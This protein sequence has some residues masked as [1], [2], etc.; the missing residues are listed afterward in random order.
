MKLLTIKNLIATLLTSVTLAVLATVLWVISTTDGAR[1][2]LTS[3]LPLSGITFSADTIE[4]SINNHLKLS[5]VR[6]GLG[7]LKIELGT[8]DLRWKPLLLM[9]GTVG[10]QQ[11]TITNLR[12]QDNAPPDNTPLNLAWPKLSGNAQLLDATIARLQISN[13]TYR[14]LQQQ[15]LHVTS[16]AGAV[17]WQDGLLSVSELKLATPDGQASGTIS[18]GF[19]QPS[20]T[21][22]LTVVLK[23]PLAEMDRFSLQIRTAKGPEQFVGKVSV[24]GSSGSRRLLELKGELGMAPNALNLRQLQLNR[25]GRKGALTGA[26]SLAFTTG[27]P[28][29]SLNINVAGLNLGP[30]LNIPTDL[31][32]T[33]TFAGTLDS[34]RGD[35]KLVNRAAGWQAATATAAYS[36]TRAGV[37]LAPFNATLLD[38]SL[39][40]TMD[41][42]WL[43]GGALRAVLNGKNLNPARLDPAWQG[44]ANFTVDGRMTWSETAPL[45]G[46]LRASLLQS[47]LHGQALTGAVQ[48]DFTDSSILLSR[49]A[50]QGKGFDLHASGDLQQRI[51]L[52]AHIT[53]FSRLIPGAA[54]KLQA[55]GWLRWR[56]RQL[57]G[58]LNGSGSRLSYAGTHIAT[59][60]LN[61][62][63][64]Q[65]AGYPLHVSTDLQNVVY[66]IYKLSNVSLE[67]DGTLP[68]HTVKAVLRSGSSAARATLAA[69]YSNGLWKGAITRLA[70]NDRSGA[71]N[72]TAPTAFSASSTHINLAP[73]ALAA[74]KTERLTAAVNLSLNPLLGKVT[75]EWSALNLGRTT[76]WLKDVRLSGTSSGKVKVGILAGTQLSL[77]GSASAS[78][79]FSGPSGSVTVRQSMLTFDGNHQGSR[80]GIDLTMA[81][82]GRIKGSFHSGSPLR[83]ALPEKGELTAEL[84][85]IDLALLK[86]WLPTDTRLA[87]RISGRAS[88]KL[89]PGQ[90]FE[91]EGTAQLPVG[92]LQQ[93]HEGELKLDF[94]SAHTTWAWRG[95]TLSGNIGLLMTRYGQARATFQL[96]LAAR[97][98]LIINQKGA[99]R[100][101]LVATVQEKG[102]ITTLFPGLVQESSGEVAAELAVSGNWA[103]PQIGGKLQLSKASAYLPTAGIHLREVQ[104]A[105]RLEKNLIRID[106][107][108]AL[109]GEGQIE[110]SARITLE[111]WQVVRYEGTLDGKNFQTVFFPELQLLSTPKLSFVGT[112]RKLT[113]RGD[114]ALPELR[115][116]GTSSRSTITPSSDVIREGQ[117]VAIVKSSPLALDVKV[118]ITLGDKVFVKASGIDAQLAGAVDLSFSTL[119]RITST[120]EINVVT[121]R[122]RTYGVNLEIVRG[123]LFFAG[124]TIDRPGL[125][126]LALR[127]IG[128]VRAGVMVAGTLQRPVTRLYSEPTMPDV[129]ILA[130]IVIGHPLG[131]SGQQTT[132]LTQAAGALLTS[133]QAAQLSEKIKNQLGLS[134][135]EIQG[136]V[137]A[138]SSSMGYTPLQVTA[139][140]AIP[141]EQQPGITETVLTVGKYL[142]PQLYISYGKSLFTGSNLF[143][144]RYDIFKQWQIETQTGSGESGAD[145]YYKL[146]FK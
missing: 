131:S 44:V 61:A 85:D 62:R 126:V 101:T 82:N 32:G 59:A 69:G 83:L 7:Q 56:D 130:Y 28:V 77:A 113:V 51:T 57:T 127:T 97:L 119:D 10:I 73:L 33:L 24:S 86:A 66:D 133:G 93:Q 25:I 98:P 103:T 90:R 60:N 104:L 124:G 43:N 111:G 135:L 87:G 54:G 106:S 23:Q 19:N 71:W 67:L 65:G 108:R 132:L 3:A 52:A 72:L 13:I 22:D 129:D 107:F 128:T 17:T 48:A 35:F 118:K 74:G 53:D 50:L 45:A 105:A 115:I 142:T 143:R 95:E 15:P 114:V 68:Q 146:E 70:G 11:L 42:I 34:Y 2:L 75:A 112:P 76:P 18:A 81:D 139:P 125:D 91:L 89:L 9:T 1:W 99:L 96:P 145:L 120:G 39:S 100:G 41:L 36:G 123:R 14:R 84:S 137:G 109:S 63:L 8:L 4:G 46:T 55:D 136:G 64:E 27:E 47:R 138:S 110:G 116:V 102:I 80:L 6:A 49:L 29:M 92:T 58:A 21:S 16:L 26:G 20:L 117:S 88:G 121:G 134:T 31:S 40:G 38:G 94:T 30:E 78:G 37:K 141:A 5:G 144:L 122:Y 140:G 12:I 79:T